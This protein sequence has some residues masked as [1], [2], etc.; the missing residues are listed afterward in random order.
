MSTSPFVR[1]LT[2]HLRTAVIVVSVVALGLGIYS[3]SRGEYIEWM[4]IAL[5]AA[6]MLGSA[7]LNALYDSY[8]EKRGA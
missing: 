1:H 2:A 7:L 5:V 8:K 6:G 3:L 4:Y